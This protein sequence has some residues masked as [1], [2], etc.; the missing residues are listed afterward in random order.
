MKKLKA[1]LHW[2]NLIKAFNARLWECVAFINSLDNKAIETIT[3]I[4]HLIERVIINNNS[5]NN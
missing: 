2:L 4:K 1:D 5:N 3:L